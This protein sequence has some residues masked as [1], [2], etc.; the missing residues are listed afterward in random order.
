MRRTEARYNWGT[1]RVSHTYTLMKG[2]MVL[3]QQEASISPFATRLTITYR[4][5][6]LGN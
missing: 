5:Y 2:F 6:R 4:D 3:A 1:V